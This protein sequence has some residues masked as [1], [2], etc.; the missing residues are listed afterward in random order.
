M[1][2]RFL[3]AESQNFEV[4][5]RVFLHG[6]CIARVKALYGYDTIE[7]ADTLPDCAARLTATFGAPDA[8][9]CFTCSY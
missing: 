8:R 4:N 6:E 2:I 1:F 7:L 3:T 9:E 5:N